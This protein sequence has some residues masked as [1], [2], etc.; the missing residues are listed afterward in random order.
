MKSVDHAAIRSG[1]RAGAGRRHAEQAL[2][3]LNQAESPLSAYELLEK[4]V[5]AG[6]TAPST[7]YR[8][9]SLLMEEGAVH[10]VDTLNAY[11]ACHGG[12]EPPA[13]VVFMVCRACHTVEE[14]TL[15]G[16]AEA[17]R[18]SM[19][20]N[21]FAFIGSTIEIKGLCAECARPAALP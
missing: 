6:I 21:G 18:E 20:E 2:S 9:L 8:A 1:S 3:V 13:L 7:V 5:P 16:I 14:V 15:P 4:L 19:T 17:L 11:V 12:H 10:R